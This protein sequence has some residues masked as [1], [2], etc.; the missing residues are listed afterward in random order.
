MPESADMKTT[1]AIIAETH[2]YGVIA[3]RGEEARVFLNN[4]LTGDVKAVTETQGLFTAWCDAKGRALATFWVLLWNDSFYLVLPEER[5]SAVI[6]GL[7][8]YI[9]RSKVKLEEV[10]H[11]LA[12]T[13]LSGKSMTAR[14]ESIIG[15][16]PPSEIHAC[17]PFQ[18]GI[19]MAIAGSPN[20]RWLLL[21]EKPRWEGIRTI[22][23]EAWQFLDVQADIPW[24]VEQTAG[25]FI[26]QMLHLERLGGLC[27][28]KGCYPGQEVIAR[29][30]YRGQLKRQMFQALVQAPSAV[31]LPG[32]RLYGEGLSESLGNVVQAAVDPDGNIHLLAVVK[33]DEKDKGTVHLGDPEGPEIRFSTG[34]ATV[35]TQ[36]PLE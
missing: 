32:T 20:P 21:G 31:P 4:L 1:D 11:S 15:M 6:M 2:G 36:G 34:A 10:P 16:T 29:L 14:L 19:V 26:P 9:F 22:P 25:E 23:A 24:I 18:T 33:L 17:L 28:T 5:V 3:V 7:G 30:H 8:R 13:G 35:C 27:F 12:L